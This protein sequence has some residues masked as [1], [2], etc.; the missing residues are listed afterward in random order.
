MNPWLKCLELHDDFSNALRTSWYRLR[1]LLFQKPRHILVELGDR[2]KINVPLRG[3]FGTLKVG[4]GV[5][6]GYRYSACLGNGEILVQARH[7]NSEI[8]IGADTILNNN[9]IVCAT[10]S[11]HI[12]ERCLIGDATMIV[13][14]D[15][16]DT[17]PAVR[18][19]SP[20]LSEPVK[21]GNNVWIGSRAMVL[22]GVTIGDNSV[23]GAK[24]L[25]TKDIP[26]NCIAAGVPAKVIKTI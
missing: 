10:K 21:I 16:H 3:G 8:V 6:F 13:D 24:S 25:V 2:V 1:F 19:S 4:T 7:P 18:H 15:F 14:S 5:T 23:I 22:K 12:G 20:G 17:D 9:S 11:I 26:P